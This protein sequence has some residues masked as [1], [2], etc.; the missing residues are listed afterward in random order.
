M[1]T[2]RII[3]FWLYSACLFVC[4]YLLLLLLL[5]YYLKLLQAFYCY[6]ETLAVGNPSYY[7]HWSGF[8]KRLDSLLPCPRLA[9]GSSVR[10]SSSSRKRA[11]VLSAI[12]WSEEDL[13]YR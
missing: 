7:T 8:V 3:S 4:C 13:G 11:Q 5:Q 6:T 2:V 12:V 9:M 10:R 1:H